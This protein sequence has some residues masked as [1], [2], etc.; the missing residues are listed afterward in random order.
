MRQRLPVVARLS[1]SRRRCLEECI[2]GRGDDRASFRIEFDLVTEDGLHPRR[3][4]YRQ[5]QIGLYDLHE[6]PPCIVCDLRGLVSGEPN[7]GLIQR[8]P[9][10]RITLPY[11]ELH[12]VETRRGANKMRWIEASRE[13]IETLQAVQLG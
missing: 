11:L 4:I 2:A 10:H 7:T 13:L 6:S 1:G 8:E 3:H 5:D 12:R 9:M